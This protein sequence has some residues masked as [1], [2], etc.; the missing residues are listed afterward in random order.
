MT[1]NFDNINEFFEDLMNRPNA[2]VHMLRVYDAYERERE[3]SKKIQ[4]VEE[5][6][7]C[8]YPESQYTAH[9]VSDDIYIV[10]ETTKGVITGYIAHVNGKKSDVLWYTFEQ[11]LLAAVSFKLT[12]NFAATEW[13][14]KLVGVGNNP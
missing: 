5:R 8:D 11:A 2:K 13:M 1:Y 9:K 6:Y 4:E 14:W 3:E 7:R 12:G 10:T